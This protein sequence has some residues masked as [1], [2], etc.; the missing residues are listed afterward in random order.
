MR[1]YDKIDKYYY[2]ICDNKF[3]D[4]GEDVYRIGNKELCTNCA[5]EEVYDLDKAEQFL[6]APSKSLYTDIRNLIP[7][8][9]YVLSEQEIYDA[10]M[11][12]YKDKKEGVVDYMT[13]VMGL[14]ECIEE[15]YEQDEFLERFGYEKIEE[16]E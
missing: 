5:F 9:T 13:C 4:C 1:V 7:I 12:A 14:K 3:K 6:F 16:D 15:N 11:K 8:L 10:L 2:H